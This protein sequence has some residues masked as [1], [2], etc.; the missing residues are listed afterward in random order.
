MKKFQKKPTT[1]KEQLSILRERGMIIPDEE[2][3]SYFLSY[4]SYYRFCGYALHFEELTLN[5]E[6]THSYKPNTC[7]ENVE[8]IYHFDAALRRLIFHYTTLIEIDFRNSLANEAAL[9]YNDP[10]WYLDETRF[11]QI[12]KHRKFIELCYSE[13]KRSREIFIKSYKKNY[14][15]GPNLPPI[16]MLIELMPFSVWSKLY[17]NISEKEL[18][19]TIAQKQGVNEKYLTSWLQALTVLRNSCAHHV[20]IWNRNFSQAPLISPRMSKKVGPELHKKIFV[21]LLIIFDLLRKFKRENEFADELIVLFQAYPEIEL[22]NLGITI[23]PEEMFS[24]SDS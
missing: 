8:R 22:K 16:W 1:V 14:P 4:C 12:D 7:F 3:A 10:H 19:K 21:M 13:T 24:S 11:K 5:G 18:V 15:A 20:R 6:R 23:L 17:Q 9:F 2:H